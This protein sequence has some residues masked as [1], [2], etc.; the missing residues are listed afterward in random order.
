MLNGVHS[1]EEPGRQAGEREATQTLPVAGTTVTPGKGAKRG[2][3]LEP[4][5]Q[6]LQVE[7]ES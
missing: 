6:G 7:P 3:H 2:A 5:C 4:R 1:N